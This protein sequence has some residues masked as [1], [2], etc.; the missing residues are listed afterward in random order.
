MQWELQ[1]HL[2][3][4]EELQFLAN[5]DPVFSAYFS[6][7]EAEFKVLSGKSIMLKRR[8]WL[9]KRS[10]NPG[11]DEFHPEMVTFWDTVAL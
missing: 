4:K 11:G 8:L 1:Y 3:A 9:L 7:E 10:G 5:L 6:V 2:V